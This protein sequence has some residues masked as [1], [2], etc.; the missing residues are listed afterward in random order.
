[1]LKLYDY[2]RSSASFRVRIALN[3]KEIDYQ[4]IPIHL[5]NNGGE[6]FSKVY[7]AIN[8][9][10]LVPTLQDGE[11]IITQ[12]LAIIEYLEDTH[13][14]PSLLPK[15]PYHRALARSFALMIAADI[16]PLN[17]LRVLK[18]L[19]DECTINENKKNQWYQHWTAKGLTALETSLTQSSLTG[20]FCFG[21]TPTIADVFL[22]PQMYNAKRFNCDTS[23]YP[24]LNRIDAHCQSLLAFSNAWPKEIA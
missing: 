17:N 21:N 18:F 14:E 2:Y 5:V 15:N 6:Q 22:I 11:K 8:P 13:P 1:M 12:S 23:A 24:L 16:H 4:Q 19:T 10:N 9:Q 7:Q 3:L 20:D